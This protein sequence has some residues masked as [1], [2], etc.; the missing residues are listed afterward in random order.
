MSETLTTESLFAAE[1]PAAA[2]ILEAAHQHL[3]SY[4]YTALT[5]DELAHELGMSKKTLYVHFAGKDAII[6]RII[7]VIGRTLRSRLDAVVNDPK[8]TFAQ[9]V[10]GIVAAAGGTLAKA[11]PTMLRD[12]QRFAPHIYRKIEDLRLKIIPVIFGRLIRNG[13]AEGMVR[14]DIDPAFATEF[15][16]HAIRGLVQPATLDRTHLTL[17]QTLEK[18]LHLFLSGLLTPAG[19]KDHEKHIAS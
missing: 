9:K 19:R 18:A 3:F 16:L 6:E 13:I 15:W 1:E 10:H 2:R 14:P 8:L 7:D 11:S 17:S 12:L 5:M 4:G